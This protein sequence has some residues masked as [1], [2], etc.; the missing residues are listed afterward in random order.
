LDR[1]TLILLI[2]EYLGV[3]AVVVLAGLSPRL[4]PRPLKFVYPRREGIVSLTLFLV[5]LTFAWFMQTGALG[6]QLVSAGD[7][8]GE[9]QRHLILSAV[10]LLPFLAALIVRRQPLLSTGWS[11]AMLGPSFRLGLA[12]AFLTIFL[13]GKVFALLGGIS[14][15]KAIL[16]CLG[17]AT[18]LLEET[19][20]RGFL[21]PRLMAW[22]GIWP[23]WALTA[24]LFTVWS[25]VLWV[26]SSDNLP[27]VL[28]LAL[29]RGLLL[30]WV[31]RRSGHVL[32]GAMYR[33][34]SDWC[35]L[36]G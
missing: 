7:S 13:R 20:F 18:C 33:A 26:G 25:A 23:G 10:A 31:A 35:F 8:I 24:I 11:R 14:Q 30:G 6:F 17:L 36:L 5:I 21:Q 3:I 2:A 22:V 32:G 27:V 29:A 4:R 16:L 12:L 9:S 19:I 28:G 34:V 15:E 1:N